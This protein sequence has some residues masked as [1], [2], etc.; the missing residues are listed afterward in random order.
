MNFIFRFLV[1]IFI[2]GYSIIVAQDFEE[3][4]GTLPESLSARKTYMVVGD[5]FVSPGS[6]VTIEAGTVILFEGFTGLHVQG[7]VF[8]K[9][10]EEKPVVFTSKNDK[11]YNPNATVD[12]APF[13]W[14]GIDIYESGLGSVFT[15]CIVR[16]SVYGIRSQTVHF[17]VV[18]C[19][20]SGNGKTDMAINGERQEIT[21]STPFSFGLPADTVK[22]KLPQSYELTSN[23][24]KETELSA[25]TPH[26]DRAG[27][28]V[29]RYTSLVIGIGS[30]A[31]SAW[32]YL[33]RFKDADKELKEL[34]SLDDEEKWRYTSKD[35]DVAKKDRDRKLGMCIAGAAGAVVGLGIFSITFA[36]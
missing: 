25:D 24:Q 31:A 15:R 13:D 11:Q 21:A 36:F 8:V 32:Y 23:L 35:W 9:G 7:T 18:E 19:I 17:K 27:L 20:F 26:K 16:F 22:P 10:E 29:L 34:S 1:C 4:S 33:K 2:T 12:A 30:G 6:S 14:N 3:L 5:I 28:Q